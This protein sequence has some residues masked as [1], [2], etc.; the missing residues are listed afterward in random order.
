MLLINLIQERGNPASSRRK[1]R[2][3][4]NTQAVESP[5]VRTVCL[6]TAPQFNVI[7]QTKRTKSLRVSLINGFFYQI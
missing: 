5:Q 1:L 6:I 2:L 3:I 7:Y 4:F